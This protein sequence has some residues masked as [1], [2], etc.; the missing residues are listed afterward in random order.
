MR[1]SRE[2]AAALQAL[3][4]APPEVIAAMPEAIRNLRPF[5]KEMGKPETHEGLAVL[6]GV[7]DKLK[8]WTNLADVTAP[9]LA[10]VRAMIL[11][12]TSD[13]MAALTRSLLEF[14]QSPAVQWLVTTGATLFANALRHFDDLLHIYIDP[15]LQVIGIEPETPEPVAAPPNEWSGFTTI[16]EKPPTTTPGPGDFIWNW[17]IRPIGYVS[18]LFGRDWGLG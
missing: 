15:L 1:L 14:V 11:A 17:V 6:N 2:Q 7:L 13:E 10:Q 8:E 16:E 9:A 12:Q 5:L 18:D 3:R 4:E